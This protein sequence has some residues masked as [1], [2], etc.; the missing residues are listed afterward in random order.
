MFLEVGRFVRNMCHHYFKKEGACKINCF[1]RKLKNII[2]VD[3]AKQGQKSISSKL[4]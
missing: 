2:L 1:F 3:I 4:N